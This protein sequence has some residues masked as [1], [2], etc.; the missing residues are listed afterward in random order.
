MT[1]GSTRYSFCQLVL[2]WGT[3]VGPEARRANTTFR[4]GPGTP[5][6]ATPC[7]AAGQPPSVRHHKLPLDT[8]APSSSA[9]LSARQGGPRYPFAPLTQANQ[10]GLLR[11]RCLFSW[12]LRLGPN[13][14]SSD[15]SVHRVLAKG[16]TLEVTVEFHGQELKDVA[17]EEPAIRVG[18]DVQYIMSS[19]NVQYTKCQVYI[20]PTTGPIVAPRP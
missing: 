18:S 17:P 15:C 3:S 12:T 11:V 1:E 7:M 6:V 20:M 13:R 2:H 4:N 5:Q 14:V 8:R 9:K 10:S 19:Y 16:G